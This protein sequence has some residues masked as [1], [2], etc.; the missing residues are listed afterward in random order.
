MTL[1]ACAGGA[2]AQGPT[3]TI[4][5]SNTSMQGSR[6]PGFVTLSN[7]AIFPTP[8]QFAQAR[9]GFD[10][11][12]YGVTPH[13]AWIP[14]LPADP[15]ARWYSTIPTGNSAAAPSALIAIPFDVP[16]RRFGASSLTLNFAVDD[17]LGSAAVSGIFVGPDGVEPTNLP[18]SSGIGGFTGQT[19][20][21]LSNL[22]GL[23]TGRNYLYLLMNNA[24]GGPGGI[25]FSGQVSV[26]RGA[27]EIVIDTDNGT[28]S[29]D[30]DSS[31]AQFKGVAFN[32]GTF[33]G[34][35]EFRIRG[36]I[37]LAASEVVTVI[38][39]MPARL[40][41]GG[42]LHMPAG[43]QISASAMASR[44]FAGGG[45]GGLPG[46][47]RLGGVSPSDDSNV[48]AVNPLGGFGGSSGVDIVLVCGARNGEPG[49]AGTP[50]RV[51]ARCRTT[52]GQA[53]DAGQ[54][55]EAGRFSSAPAAA[56]GGGGAAGV[57][58]SYAYDYTAL[59][60]QVAGGAGGTA[61]Y[62][63]G[64]NGGNGVNGWIGNFP[65][66]ADPGSDG[67]SGAH[68]R[69]A[70]NATA[71]FGGGG[72]AAGGGGGGATSGGNGLHGCP[73]S[74]GGGG[75]G[76]SCF[77]GAAGG[78]GG[79]GGNGGSGGAGGAGGAG[80]MA[81][82][83]GGVVE[84][85]VLGR[86]TGQGSIEASGARGFSGFP[87]A[88]GKPGTPGTAGS[89]G[90]AGSTTSTGAGNGGAGG[91]GGNGTAGYSGGRGGNGGGGGGGAGGAVL[92]YSSVCEFTGLLTARAGVNALQGG[93]D[94][95][96]HV[97][98]NIGASPAVSGIAFAHAASDAPRAV[99]AFVN[100]T[101]PYIP[102]LV[103][104]P[105]PFG[106]LSM[107]SGLSQFA[108]R[109]A[110]ALMGFRRLSAAPAGFP[111][112]PGFQYCI[113][114]NL[115][116]GSLNLAQAGVG[117]ALRRLE[118]GGRD[119][120][121]VLGSSFAA[122]NPMPA[123]SV[124]LT[125]MPSAAASPDVVMR[126]TVNGVVHNGAGSGTV[127]NSVYVVAPAPC[128]A[129]FDR[130]GALSPDDLSDFIGCYFSQPPCSGG[131]FNVDGAVD[132]DDL[133]DYIGAYFAGC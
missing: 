133:A 39:S 96:V 102:G 36:D 35:R 20:Y 75:G 47:S 122:L 41:I 58:S 107:S 51:Q 16:Y 77:R 129:D 118:R 115:S 85:R 28:I 56:G 84:V 1:L 33:N 12:L 127:N 17:Q 109:P 94:G 66:F 105:A 23:A 55:G 61:G 26:S 101:T 83:G 40:I 123:G 97:A 130:D 116:G 95:A 120:D 43:S 124:W 27:G 21:T 121:P 68:G 31:D 70:P 22:P 128:A 25:I 9:S 111:E 6:Q 67:A 113:V 81:G 125:L 63:L 29:N 32:T 59:L 72:G 62:A 80:G 4:T 11:M 44:G 131:D 90:S 34:A 49:G 88:F 126:C 38:G 54:A 52:G 46:P 82:G 24:G 73:G 104:G 99:N 64:G 103:D 18:A 65:I 108:S 78:A 117:A 5:L 42:N 48:L 7:T 86:V 91:S 132:P 8:G 13:P 106:Y 87:G 98:Y 119:N 112:F 10:G 57:A 114:A 30:G 53:G 60:G 100:A 89:P 71:L 110:R 2:L 14:L 76:I 37:T 93:N 3:T 45:D 15:Q 50:G 74:G 69:A 92:L 79:A 19:T